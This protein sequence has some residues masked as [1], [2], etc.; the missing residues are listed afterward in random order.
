LREPTIG[1]YPTVYL[2]FANSG[3]Q[4][5]GDFVAS[6][7]EAASSW[8]S[9]SVSGLSPVNTQSVRIQL[10]WFGMAAGETVYLD[11]A[12]LVIS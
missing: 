5:L 9:G 3:N 1:H 6:P 4:F 11:D 10:T 8:F 7:T 2:R 12:S